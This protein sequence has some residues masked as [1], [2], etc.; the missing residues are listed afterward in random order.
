MFQNKGFKSLKTAVATALSNLPTHSVQTAC[1]WIKRTNFN[2]YECILYM[3]YFCTSHQFGD[4]CV[5][6]RERKKDWGHHL[7]L[8]EGSYTPPTSQ[9][10]KIRKKILIFFS[11]G[12]KWRM[13]VKKIIDEIPPLI[14]TFFIAL[15]F[16][17]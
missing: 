6:F 17:F 11:N 13:N 9:W 10:A 8:H 5:T 1:R 16:Y 14:F 7:V 3:Y 15:I 4:H 2:N 12:A